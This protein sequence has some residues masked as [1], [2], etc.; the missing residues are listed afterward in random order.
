MEERESRPSQTR[1]RLVDRPRCFTPENIV[2]GRGVL[3]PAIGNEGTTSRTWEESARGVPESIFQSLLQPRSIRPWPAGPVRR[4]SPAGELRIDSLSG[5]VRVTNLFDQP[6][7]IA[8][9]N[10]I[11]YALALGAGLVLSL[12]APN[13]QAAPIVQSLTRPT[14]RRRSSTV[15]SPRR[16]AFRR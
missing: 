10:K 2:K 9:M 1:P 5:F 7:K 13:A 16:P 12:A 11:T 3:E 14:C 4:R 8:R 15:C 6:W